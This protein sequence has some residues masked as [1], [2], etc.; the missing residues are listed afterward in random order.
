MGARAKRRRRKAMADQLTPSKVAPKG[1]AFTLKTS[2]KTAGRM[3][4][5]LQGAGGGHTPLTMSANKDDEFSILA[6]PPSSPPPKRP[7]IM[8]DGRAAVGATA[9]GAG[10]CIV[11]VIIGVFAVCIIF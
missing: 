3:A 1:P 5:F 10:K 9:G 6:S 11:I 4:A 2:S 7:N 8:D